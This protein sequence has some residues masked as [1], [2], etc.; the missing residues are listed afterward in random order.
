MPIPTRLTERLLLAAK[1]GLGAGACAAS[2]PTLCT[3]QEQTYWTGRMSTDHGVPVTTGAD[4]DA[5]PVASLCVGGPERAAHLVLRYARPGVPPLALR[6]GP[7][8]RFHTFTAED[9]PHHG[10]HVIWTRV[11]DTD[12]CLSAAT[13]QGRGVGLDIFVGGR[14]QHRLFSGIETGV[15]HEIADD[16]QLERRVKS[17]LRRSREASCV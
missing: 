9:G 2:P 7:R 10:R 6:S 1:L 17:L 5:L 16:P 12:Y 3:D 4:T 14:W 15:S 13:A 8:Q 11:G